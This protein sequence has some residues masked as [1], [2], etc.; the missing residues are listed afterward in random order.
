MASRYGEQVGLEYVKAP[1]ILILPGYGFNVVIPN[2][3][4]FISPMAFAGLGTTFNT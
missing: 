2:S 3:K 1:G 4:I